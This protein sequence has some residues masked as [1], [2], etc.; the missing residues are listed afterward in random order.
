MVQQLVPFHHG[1][2]TYLLRW[3]TEHKLTAADNGNAA[4]VTQVIADNDLKK[5]WAQLQVATL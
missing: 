3:A 2:L 5:L 1:A 4:E